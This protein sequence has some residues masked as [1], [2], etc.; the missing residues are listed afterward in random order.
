MIDPKFAI[1]Y[2]AGLTL[3]YIICCIFAKL[4]VGMLYRREKLDR[5][6]AENCQI[7]INVICLLLTLVLVGM[8]Y[9]AIHSLTP[10]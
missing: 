6:T 2:Y 10:K 4:I 9:E 3:F 7:T 5:E 8:S 1:F